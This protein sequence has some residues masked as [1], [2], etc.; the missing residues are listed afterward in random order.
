M[1]HRPTH[2]LIVDDDAS[3]GEAL[4]RLLALEGYAVQ[5][6]PDGQG[7]LERFDEYDPDVVVSDLRMPMIDGFDLLQELRG[8]GFDVPVIMV[9]GMNDVRSAVAAIRAGAADYLTK[10]IDGDALLFAVDRAIRTRDL[11]REAAALRQR[12]EQLV[13]EAERNVRAREELLSILVHDLRGP[14]ATISLAATSES[15]REDPARALEIISRAATRMSRLVEDLLDVSRIETG[16]L[17]LDVASHRAS[18]IVQ[19][20]IAVLEPMA[21]A[22]GVRLESAVAADFELTCSF[23]RLVQALVNLGSN[24]LDVV[25]GGRRVKLA[26][27]RRGDRARFEV[28]DDGPGIAPD[29]LARVFDRGWRKSTGRHRGAGMGLAIVKG[30]VEAHGGSIGIQSTVGLG[31]KFTIDVPLLAPEHAAWRVA[32]V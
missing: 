7:A 18:N 31:T 15:G 30:I 10:P 8:R 1:S 14:L 23:E 5:V 9:T 13:A 11:V 20:A 12:N 28:E 27:E 17:M 25:P 21:T 2:V 16:G 6:A 24:A 22:N 4:G 3:D 19:E 32:A 29:H 26:A